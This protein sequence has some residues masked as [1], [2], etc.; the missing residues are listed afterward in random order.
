[1]ALPTR[2]D[3]QQL[4]QAMQAV[5]ARLDRLVELQEQTAHPPRPV[6]L[7]RDDATQ[8]VSG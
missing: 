8:G 2:E 5:L 1:M 4:E 6:I 7:I 3:F